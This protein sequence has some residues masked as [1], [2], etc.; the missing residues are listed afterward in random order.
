MAKYVDMSCE[1]ITKGLKVIREQACA[2][3]A[4]DADIAYRRLV[5][6]IIEGEGFIFMATDDSYNLSKSD[7]IELLREL[8]YAIETE[9][10]TDRHTHTDIVTETL[11]SVLGY[12]A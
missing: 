9:R 2:H 6:A 11:D 8:L 4:T 7:M 3:D 1:T 10:I 12:L 5:E